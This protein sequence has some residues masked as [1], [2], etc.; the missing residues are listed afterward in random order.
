MPNELR[1][2]IIAILPLLV[3][4]VLIVAALLIPDLR[5]FFTKTGLTAFIER[6]GWY[7]PVALGLLMAV[8][9]VL[10]PIP[11]VPISAVLGMAY[12]SLAGTGIAV[13][14]ALLG[15]VIAFLIA[16]HI[17]T[18]AI[19]ALAG[20]QVRFCE[21]CSERSLS[22]IV[23]VAR[24]IPVVSFDVVSYG[25]GMSRMRFSRFVLWSFVGMIPWT[26]FYTSVGSAVLDHPT[27]AAVLGV[28]LAV[29]VLG[30][31]ALIRKY[32]P[33]GLRRVMMEQNGE[34]STHSEDADT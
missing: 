11:N 34:A 28:V 18:R 33:F 27:L 29:A 8:S 4:G 30:L 6:A 1:K 13:A 3:L 25:A 5:R 12:G 9:V 22:I 20:R 2:N 32:D 16:R 14:G 10:S 24:L 23:F 19:R 7:A 26:W 31:P 17:G 15:A 21:G